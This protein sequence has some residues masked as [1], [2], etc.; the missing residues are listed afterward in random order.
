MHNVLLIFQFQ[1]EA[2]RQKVKTVYDQLITKQGL[3][4]LL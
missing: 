2:M 3:N 1:D 4:S